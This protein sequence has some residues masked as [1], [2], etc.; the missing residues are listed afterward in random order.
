MT[1]KKKTLLGF[2]AAAAALLSLS[3]CDL[4]DDV[5][6]YS[7]TEICS[8]VDGRLLTDN[9]Y[10]FN[11]VRNQSASG[12]AVTSLRRALVL[13]DI[14]NYT[15]GKTDEFD[16]NLKDFAEVSIDDVIKESEADEE[17][18]G[19]DAAA[20]HSA[21]L[22]KDYLNID[23]SYTAF[24]SSTVK[25]DIALVLDDLKSNADTVYLSLRHNA[26]GESFDD[27]SLTTGIDVIG[28]IFSY[29][30]EQVI[31]DGTESIVLCFTWDWFKSVNGIL[32]KDREVFTGCL[33][34]EKKN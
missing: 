29:P 13:C 14:L 1:L 3:S 20:V 26:H 34:W 16:I 25:H 7:Q 5:L 19:D 12:T 6:A 23:A 4:G 32:V 21:W 27:A 8:I 18:L 17:A 2:A 15:E 30:V 22:S 9:G 10:Y 24:T 31:P 28:Q 33:N 11:I